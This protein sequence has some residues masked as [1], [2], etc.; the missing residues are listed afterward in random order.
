MQSPAS[1]PVAGVPE[2]ILQ[3]YLDKSSEPETWRHHIE[4]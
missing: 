3:I 2:V 4:R 1:T